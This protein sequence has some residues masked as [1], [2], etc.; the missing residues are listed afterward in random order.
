[1]HPWTRLLLLLVIAGALAPSSAFAGTRDKILRDCQDGR[2]DGHYSQKQYADALANIPTDVDEYTDCRDVIRRSQLSSAGSPT[3]GG[4]GGTT[5]GSSTGT[6]G[7]SGSSRDPL[8]TA[9]RHERDT[10]E[11]KQAEPDKSVN[12]GGRLVQPSSLGYETGGSFSDIPTSLL[13]ALILLGAGAVVAGGMW[14]RSRVDT[15]RTN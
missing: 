14:L 3:G 7:A 5:G 6:T 8:A 10:L 1:M 11:R 9:S 2:I 12:L 15:R 13:I 4:G